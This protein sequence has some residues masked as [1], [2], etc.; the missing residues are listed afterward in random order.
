MRET[1]GATPSTIS[2]HMGL[3]AIDPVVRNYATE[4][5][6]DRG[7]RR[8]RC[9]PLSSR[10]RSR[11]APR[12]RTCRRPPGTVTRA[13]K[14]YDRRVIILRRSRRSWQRAESKVPTH[15]ENHRVLCVAKRYPRAI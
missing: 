4:L 1:A 15:E 3:D 13:T 5:G 12:P 8:T 2:R 9:A 6:L 11:T 10:R 14:L 7:Y